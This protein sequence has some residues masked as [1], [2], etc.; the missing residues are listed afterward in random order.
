M[1]SCST[2]SCLPADL[3]EAVNG[4]IHAS[5][6]LPDIIARYP[7]RYNEHR[8]RT[9]QSFLVPFAEIRT[10][11]WDLS[12]N[13]YKELVYEEVKYDKPE[14]ILERIKKFDNERI[15][16]FTILEELLNE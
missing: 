2:R 14:V 1:R 6:N 4:K 3:P 10:N 8:A 9:E 12:I 16:L 15:E 13:R 11:E 5:F 7:K